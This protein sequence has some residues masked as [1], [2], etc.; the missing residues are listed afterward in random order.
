MNIDDLT[1]KYFESI[2]NEI[3][4]RVQ[5]HYSL[6]VYKFLLVGGVLSFLISSTCGSK[7][8]PAFLVSSI[9]AFL[10]DFI[11]LENLGWIRDAG[12]F[13]K[14]HIEDKNPG[15]Q[16]NWESKFIQSS[17]HWRCFDWKYYLISSWSIGPLLIAGHFVVS[18]RDSDTLESS[19]E[20]ISISL[21]VISLMVIYI[22]L[23]RSKT[24]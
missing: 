18:L 13:I 2:R 20:V 24:N 10:F 6:V 1:L 7:Q 14:N 12:K 19:L 17:K 3:N 5:T 15:L 4:Q 11:I 23:I 22:K 16:F 21:A 8:I 9:F